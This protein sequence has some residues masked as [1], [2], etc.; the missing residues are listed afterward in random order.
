VKSGK[1]AAVKPKGGTSRK[2]RQNLDGT[3]GLKTGR[4]HVNAIAIYNKLAEAFRQPRA[5]L[6]EIESI[7]VCQLIASF[8]IIMTFFQLFVD[9]NLFGCSQRVKVAPY[10][11][12]IRRRQG[13]I[14]N[15]P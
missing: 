12:I 3:K 10:G 7:P 9:I 14:L 4:R 6:N 15:S 8:I 1:S 11:E 5:K 13:F 2:T